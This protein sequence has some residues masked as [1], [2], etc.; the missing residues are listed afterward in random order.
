LPDWP[1][2]GSLPQFN[3][4]T[5]LNL[6]LEPVIAYGMTILACSLN[7]MHI[8]FGDL[9]S[10]QFPICMTPMLGIFAQTRVFIVLSQPALSTPGINPVT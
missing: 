3:T 6:L 2:S 1:S 10:E 5:L 4:I 9:I 8:L 7:Q